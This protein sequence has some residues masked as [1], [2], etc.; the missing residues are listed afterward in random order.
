MDIILIRHGESEANVRKEFGTDETPLSE[1]G[2]VQ[3]AKT[4]D[5]IG[6][7]KYDKVYVSPLRRARE[8][9]ELLGL[10]GE[11]REEVREISFGE[12]EGK[13]YDTTREDC[14][15]DII[16][17]TEDPLN[18]RVPGGETI[19]E[20]YFRMKPFF[21]ELVEKNEDVIIVTHDGTVRM[22]MCYVLEDYKSFYKFKSD[23]VSVSKI[24]IEKSGE[25]VIAF[26]NKTVY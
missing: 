26:T 10:N 14:P 5:Y 11:I 8:T 21:D 6:T 12:M 15:E 1:L 16:R 23:N 18:Y 22:G 25:K 4:K 7:L 17:W 13:T 3:A 24:S 19:E 2:R 20:A 9:M